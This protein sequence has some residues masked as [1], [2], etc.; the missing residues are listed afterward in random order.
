MLILGLKGLNTNLITAKPSLQ[1]L[2]GRRQLAIYREV[3]SKAGGA[4]KYIYIKIFQVAHPLRG[5]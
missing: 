5:S 3:K 1:V 4:K 2:K